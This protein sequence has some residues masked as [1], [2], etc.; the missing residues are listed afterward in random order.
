MLSSSN[1]IFHAC[2]GSYLIQ[3]KI[4]M[5][6]LIELKIKEQPSLHIL[7][8]VLKMQT[9]IIYY[10]TNFH[11]TLFGILLLKHGAHVKGDLQLIGCILKI[12]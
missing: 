7:N 3:M 11:N 10:I 9:Y 2:I 8:D 6:Y 4:S 5:L 12:I 1:Y